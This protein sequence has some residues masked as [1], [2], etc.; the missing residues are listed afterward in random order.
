M[1]CPT[2]VRF[3]TNIHVRLNDSIISFLRFFVISTCCCIFALGQLSCNKL[4]ALSP[5]LGT[6]YSVT[7]CTCQH[8]P[9]QRRRQLSSLDRALILL[10]QVYAQRGTKHLIRTIRLS[11]CVLHNVLA[12]RVRVFP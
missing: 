12:P 6:D 4:Y 11:L 9:E 2:L 7:P 8:Y 5:P 1:R 10:H 3:A